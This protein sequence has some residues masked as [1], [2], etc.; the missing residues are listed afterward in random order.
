VS[1][2]PAEPPL[3][4]D[5]A[6]VDP[7]WPD[8]TGRRLRLPPG[9]VYLALLVALALVAALLWG[10]GGFR[11]RTDVLEDTAPG[12]LVTAGPY[13][14]RFS[15]VTAQQRTDFRGGVTWRVTVMGEGRTT[16]DVTIAPTSVGDHAMFVAKDEASG[17]VE[18]PTSQF[19]RTSGVSGLSGKRSKKAWNSVSA[20]RVD[21]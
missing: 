20:S 10:L 14:L 2:A 9:A 3:W 15:E 13:E 12:A 18:L 21:V 1:T 17:E 4:L 11:S 16:G 8:P 7:A 19:F 5:E 6:Q